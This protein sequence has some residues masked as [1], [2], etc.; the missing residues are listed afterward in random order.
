MAVQRAAQ[1]RGDDRS[2]AEQLFKAAEIFTVEQTHGD[3]LAGG[4]DG[5]A[6]DADIDHAALPLEGETAVLRVL[7]VGGIHLGVGLDTRDD[8]GHDAV[9]DEM[10]VNDIAVNAVTHPAAGVIVL[11]RQ[12]DIGGAALQRLGQNIVHG[13]FDEHRV[14]GVARQVGEDAEQ[15]FARHFRLLAHEARELGAVPGFDFDTI[16]AAAAADERIGDAVKLFLFDLVADGDAQHAI[17]QIKEADARGG[18]RG[19]R[20]IKTQRL[21][22]QIVAHAGHLEFGQRVIGEA[23]AL[24]NLVGGEMAPARPVHRLLGERQLIMTGVDLGLASLKRFR[25][26]VLRGFLYQAAP[27]VVC[28]FLNGGQEKPFRSFS[29]YQKKIANCLIC[30]RDCYQNRRD[31]Y[32]KMKNAGRRRPKRAGN[33]KG[34]G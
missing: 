25:R 31:Y 7:A 21:H 13:L 32:R 4:R 34:R 5:Q 2:V 10:L 30:L 28:F 15:A 11:Q 19:R 18:L 14:I 29:I 3:F 12:V 24:Q 9:G 22:G 8:R 23:V 33:R 1:A 26:S 16:D 20:D 17:A 6:G 27:F